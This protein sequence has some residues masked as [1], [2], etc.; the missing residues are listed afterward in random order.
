MA[1]NTRRLAVVAAAR[2]CGRHL[3]AALSNIAALASCYDDA[4]F[5]FAVSDI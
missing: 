4:R 2:D 1:T 5:V 3:P